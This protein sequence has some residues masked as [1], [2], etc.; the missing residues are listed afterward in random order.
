[1]PKPGRGGNGA[2]WSGGLSAS[3]IRCVTM[4]ANRVAPAGA[5]GQPA[6]SGGGVNGS[7]T[8][9]NSIVWDND[10]P[11]ISP[12]LVVSFCDVQG[13]YAGVGN[14][15]ADPRFVDAPNGN[16]RLQVDSPCV[17]AGNNAAVQEST[18]LEGNPRITDGDVSGIATVDMGAYEGQFTVS[19]VGPGSP[20]RLL[21]VSRAH[22]TPNVLHVGFTLQRPSTVRLALYDAAGRLQRVLA[23][24]PHPAGAHAM[25]WDGRRHDGSS[26][27]RGVYFLQ[28]RTSRA[29]DVE[30][31][32]WLQR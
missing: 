24:G 32:V 8:I 27:A 23:H 5:E 3:S 12:A 29:R 26:V 20:A 1:M 4:N 19:D 21:Q 31:I 2:A 9:E 13:G 11:Q 10:A 7:A 30:K 28:L 15:D 16:L 17:D 6:G 18:D 25:T 14:I 22:D